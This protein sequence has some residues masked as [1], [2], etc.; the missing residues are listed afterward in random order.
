M[1]GCRAVVFDLSGTLIDSYSYGREADRYNAMLV[2]IADALG[3]AGSAFEKVWGAQYR[4]RWTGRF[5]TFEAAI[6]HA[7][8]S[9]EIEP[10]P[11]RVAAAATVRSEFMRSMPARP[12]AAETLA[13][14][15]DL[16][17]K[18]GVISNC[19]PDVAAFWPDT[20]L[21]R[22][23]DVAVLSC[24]VGFVKPDPAIFRTACERL[25]VEPGECV[26][27]A[28][29]EGGELAAARSL[30]MQPILIRSSY[31]DPPFFRQPHVEPWDGPEIAWL[32]DLVELICG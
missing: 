19:G 2:R 11:G 6:E 9:L 13:A 20:E 23:V 30:G 26:Y 28:D 32:K 10:V 27:V 24:V 3:V 15:R 17:L 25:S 4:D 14:I 1:P 21:A 12:D 18:T 16:G 8:R 5:P 31:R 22:L 7:A 29:G